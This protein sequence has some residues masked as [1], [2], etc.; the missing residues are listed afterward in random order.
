MGFY[1]PRVVL[2]LRLSGQ[3]FYTMRGGID[4]GDHRFRPRLLKLQL[5]GRISDPGMGSYPPRVALAL[6]VSGWQVPISQ[7]GWGFHTIRGGIDP[8]NRSFHPRRLEFQMYGRISVSG[9]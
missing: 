9:M 7:W 2:A 5:N 6:R 3:G 8:G 4:P 1:H